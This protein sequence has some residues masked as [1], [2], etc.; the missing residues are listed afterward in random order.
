MPEIPPEFERYQRQIALGNFGVKSQKNLQ[1]SSLAIIGAGGVG[2]A[3]LPLLAGSGIGKIKIIDCD[4][5]SL[6]NLH[7][8]TIYSEKEIGLSKADAAKERLSK[9]NSSANID[10][11]D[12]KITDAGALKK[13]LKNTDIC[14][15]ATDSFKTRFIVSDACKSLQIPEIYASAQG[16]VSQNILFC[17]N[18]YLRDFMED[19]NFPNEEAQYLPIFPPA[20]HLSGIWAAATAIKYLAKIED[21]KA[22][23]FKS[24]NFSSDKFSSLEF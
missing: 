3:A 20:A 7:R 8:Q 23:F 4:R 11:F 6:A 22:G 24:Y 21:F 12:I 14:I 9:L 17:K 10:I 19:E 5:V 16:Y 13:I 1:R 2:S 15:D 18:F